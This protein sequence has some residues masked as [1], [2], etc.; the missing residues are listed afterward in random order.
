MNWD[1][2]GA[3]LL[4]VVITLVVTILKEV[5][6]AFMKRK[7]ERAHVTVQLVLLLD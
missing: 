5:I 2:G 7:A 6:T 3:V 1:K 4:G